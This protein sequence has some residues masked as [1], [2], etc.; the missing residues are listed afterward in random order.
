MHRHLLSGRH[1]PRRSAMATIGG[2]PLALAGCGAGTWLGESEDPPLP[3]ERR[4][5]LATE[6]GVQADPAL[7]GTSV[8]VPAPVRNPAWPQ[9]GGGPTHA[10][11]HLAG[12]DRLALAWQVGIGEGTGGSSRLL[13]GPVVADGRVYT[14]DAAGE[15]RATG[16][17]DG[18]PLW[19]YEAEDIER[20]DRDLGGGCA[21]A[22]DRLYVALGVGTVLALDAASGRELWRQSVAAPV[23][24]APGVAGGLVL[25][26][27]ADNQLM[28]LDAGSGELQWRHTGLFEQA[29]ILGGASPAADR[30]L[31]V[32]AY[33]SGEVYALELETGRPVWTETVLRPRRTQAIAA[34]PDIVGDPVIDGERVLVAGVS[35]EMVALDLTRGSRLWAQRIT[36]TQMPWAA[37]ETT[38]LVTERNEV[39]CL[40]RDGG[41]RWV[42]PL[43]T[44]T[45]PDDP[46]STRI[47]WAGPVL[48][49]ERLVLASSARALIGLSP[50][51]GEVTGE[52]TLPSPV[53]LPPAVAD[54]TIY[55]LGDDARLMAYR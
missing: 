43:A 48:V 4:A 35:G 14:V 7:S 10:P 31:V 1:L 17:A 51:T 22:G 16:A 15:I 28:A 42:R 38:F 25:V 24:A 41:I 26:P 23:R 30:G 2:L 18:E 36:S 9:A 53:T 33:S 40:L 3:G 12:G 44:L 54:G 37:G 52:T 32:V 49:A 19:A 45:D 21:F 8:T 6:E 55:F 11:G 27:T 34:I 47:R 5:V 20:N 13:S 29:G 50:A 46:D 39:A